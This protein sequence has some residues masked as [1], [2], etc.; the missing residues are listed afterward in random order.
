MSLAERGGLF[1]SSPKDLKMRNGDTPPAGHMTEIAARREFKI[2]ERDLRRAIGYGFVRNPIVPGYGRMI[3][4][5]DLAAF[6]ATYGKTRPDTSRPRKE[7]RFLEMRW[8]A[9]HVTETDREGMMRVWFS[10]PRIMGIRP[11]ISLGKEDFNSRFFDLAVQVVATILSTIILTCE[12][13]IALALYL[14]G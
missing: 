4:R 8:P 6:I 12:R 9:R 1:L 11:G 7:G 2:S 3:V 5:A 10:G 14:K 13:A